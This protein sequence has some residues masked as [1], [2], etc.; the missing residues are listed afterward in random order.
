MSRPGNGTALGFLPEALIL[1]FI[2]ALIA[3]LPAIW[4]LLLFA[5]LVAGAA[6]ATRIRGAALWEACGLAYAAL[7]GFSLA[8][9]R[10]GN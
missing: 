2:G 1:I 3:G 9:L 5:I 6:I 10:D 8:Y 7:S 4:L